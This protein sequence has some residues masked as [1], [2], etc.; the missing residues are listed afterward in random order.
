MALRKQLIQTT[1]ITLGI[2]ALATAT[3]A[4][5]TYYQYRDAVK[6]ITS[7]DMHAWYTRALEVQAKIKAGEV[8]SDNVASAAFNWK[9]LGDAT[10]KLYFYQKALND[11]ALVTKHE[12][13]K[14]GLFF[15]NAGNIY[16]SLKQ[17]QKADDQYAQ[18]VQLDTG[19]NVNTLARIALWQVWPEKSSDD[20][21][22]LFDSSLKSVLDTANIML[23]KAEYLE[24]IGRYEEAIR[25]YQALK[26]TITSRVETTEALT[27]KVLDLQK[28]IEAART[29]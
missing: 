27:R 16:R 26:V 29:H 3:F 2:I 5:Y 9:S 6:S 21:L 7:D 13:L 8:T 4:G 14:S 18:A 10:G 17:Y 24:K 23:A 19:N 20:V 1:I 22:D 15:L 11:Y 25:I 12:E 28:K